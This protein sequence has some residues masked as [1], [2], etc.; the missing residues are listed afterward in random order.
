MAFKTS[1]LFLR[2]L[3]KAQII[4]FAKNPLRQI[5]THVSIV[6][7]VVSFRMLTA[8]VICFLYE[9]L[10]FVSDCYNLTFAYGAK[11]IIVF[12]FY[13]FLYIC[14]VHHFFYS[15]KL[16]LPFFPCI[17]ST[18]WMWFFENENFAAR[19]AEVADVL[20]LIS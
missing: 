19:A 18:E 11:S 15:I 14:T 3:I 2:F 13:F 7:F 9:Q 5:F 6:I 12:V 20:E 17:F 10:Y 4:C 16:Y 8:I 1:L